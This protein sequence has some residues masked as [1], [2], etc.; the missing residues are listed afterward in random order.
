[1]LDSLVAL[2][3]SEYNKRRKMKIDE[4]K[5]QFSSQQKIFKTD[6][7]TKV[8]YLIAEKLSEKNKSLINGELRLIVTFIMLIVVETL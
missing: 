1:M 7:C 2:N 8:S 5:K 6:A 4:L 3:K